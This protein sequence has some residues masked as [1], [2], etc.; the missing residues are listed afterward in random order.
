MEKMVFLYVLRFILY[1]LH[2]F[3]SCFKQTID[4]NKAMFFR[5]LRREAL[6]DLSTATVASVHQGL[7]EVP[8]KRDV[9]WRKF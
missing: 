9:L 4:Y 3:L 7:A 1:D 8:S 5:Y 6:G 2:G